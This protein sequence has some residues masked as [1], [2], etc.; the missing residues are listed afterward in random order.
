[1]LQISKILFPTDFS[2]CANQALAHARYLAAQHAA[3]V[4]ILHALVL[5]AA[6]WSE[7][8]HGMEEAEALYRR[9]QQESDAEL[10]ASADAMATENLKIE[11]A[12]RRGFS[13]APVILDYADD[14]DIDLV[15]MSTHGRRGMRRLLLGSVTDEVMRLAP[16][17]V[18]AVPMSE[19]KQ[20]PAQ[21]DQIVVPVDFSA[22]TELALAYAR[23][24]AASQGARLRLIHVIQEPIYPE[25]Y[26]PMMPAAARNG[27][28]L[29][30]RSLDHL[31][32]LLTEVEGPEVKGD[33][34]VKAG[35]PEEEIAEFAET[36]GAG[37]IVMASHGLTGLRHVFLGSVAEQTIRRAPCP[38]FTVKAF[39]KR[40]I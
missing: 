34:T 20:T 7:A 40:L 5:H 11:K 37:L 13:A 4:H 31:N 6:D 35:R 23:E 21:L 29:R 33:V 38:V 14:C 10:N 22:H 2:D 19:K 25:F 32:E 39:G 18:L 24:L 28:L 1:M 12:T 16:C 36:E 9:V 26:G 30:E 15:V 17:P 27:E 3:E 8:A